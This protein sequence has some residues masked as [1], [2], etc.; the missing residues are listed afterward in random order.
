MARGQV[1]DRRIRNARKTVIRSRQHLKATRRPR[2]QS[3][4]RVI[5]S[6]VKL[7]TLVSRLHRQTLSKKV[8]WRRASREGVFVAVFSGYA[9]RLSRHVLSQTVEDYVLEV[10][11]HDGGVIEKI[12]DGCFSR[13]QPANEVFRQLKET[14]DLARRAVM[15]SEGAID[16]ILEE[17]G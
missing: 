8:P 13:P 9:L 17:L 4:K 14:Y 3:L 7:A 6:E 16:S 11:D 2:G 15:G 10:C 1:G 5:M 12:S